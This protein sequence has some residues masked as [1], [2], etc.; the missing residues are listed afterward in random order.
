MGRAVIPPRR[1]RA[2]RATTYQAGGIDV[3]IG[4]RCPDM[5]FDR[6]DAGTA[7]LLTAWNPLS[8]RM[9]EGWN[10]RMQQRLRQALHRFVVL[11]AEGSLHRWHEAMLLV[12][13]DPRPL[14]RLA[15]RFRQRALVCLRRGQRARLWWL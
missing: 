6:L 4:R 9:P 8:R 13:G 10:R 7:V 2:Y 11:D 1:L 14:T 15:A 3:H 12:A 5:L